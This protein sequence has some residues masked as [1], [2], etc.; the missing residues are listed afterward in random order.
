[1][2]QA[3]VTLF[4]EICTALGTKVLPFCDEVMTMLYHIAFDHSV[5]RLLK[6]QT[7]AAFGDVALAIGGHFTKYWANVS[8]LLCNYANLLP[9]M[10]GWSSDY[11]MELWKCCLLGY[12]GVVHGLKDE[13]H[14]LL[15][16][17]PKMM[18]IVI[19]LAC[20]D[21]MDDETIAAVVG[22]IGDLCTEFDEHVVQFVDGA[23]IELLIAGSQS[24]LKKTKQLSK[25]AIKEITKIKLNSSLPNF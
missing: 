22:F 5:D 9:D 24:E 4:R 6:P 3:S 25:W 21:K 2:C 13:K 10:D 11:L 1:M 8:S 16:F 12:T 18:D 15:P 19:A 7:L 14:L 20:Y 23:V 17:V